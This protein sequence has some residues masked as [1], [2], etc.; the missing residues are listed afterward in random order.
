MVI[1]S[2]ARQARQNSAYRFARY[3]RPDRK[4]GAFVL[5]SLQTSM[6]KWIPV[7]LV[8]LLALAGI[9]FWSLGSLPDEPVA[10]ARVSEASGSVMLRRGESSSVEVKVGDELLVGDRVLTSAD[11]SAVL[12]WFG[13]G[14]SRISTSTEVVIERLGQTENGNLILDLRLEAGRIW[15]RMQSLLDIDADVVVHTQDVIATV[16][17]TAFDLE[18]RTN[19]PTTLW[20]SDSVVEATGPTVAATID[21]LLV[22][23]GSM[24]KFGGAYRTTST[25]PISA[26]GTQSDWFI[27]NGELDRKFNERARQ[28]LR[29]SLGLGRSDTPGILRSI[30]DL[31]QR[32]RGPAAGARL[33]LR[34]LAIIRDEAE[35]GAEGKAAEDF[36]RLEREVRQQID[37]GKPAAM[38]ALRRALV[39]SRRLFEDVMP[40]TPA[41]RYKQALEDIR[42]RVARSAAERI[43][44]RLLAIADRLDEGS[45]ALENGNMDLA[46]RMVGIAEQTLANL[47]RELQQMQATEREAKI[48]R[49]KMRALS[50]R[51]AVLR[52]RATVAPVVL[53]MQPTSTNMQIDTKVQI[54]ING[55][56]I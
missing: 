35:N 11:G 28:A 7:F 2:A 22:V 47:G 45:M 8:F 9:W 31:S 12:D 29:A 32:L 27:N 16:R 49:A 43:F 33:I 10:T 18:K 52:T 21:G 38:I 15:S 53:P 42:D 20:V 51:A 4:V 23:E 30:S 19:L 17:G 26:S 48:V 39:G 34:R 6:R 56:P 36:A 37:S 46:G 24:A 44:L 3:K 25:M 40:E 50:A 14:E 54:L 5:D 13:E 41:Y 55:K 1:L